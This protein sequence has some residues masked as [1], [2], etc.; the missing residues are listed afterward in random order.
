[1]I[2][3]RRKHGHNIHNV[4]RLDYF[5]PDPQA[6]SRAGNTQITSHLSCTLRCCR[7]GAAMM[8]LHECVPRITADNVNRPVHVC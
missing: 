7:S 3:T 1:M 2:W 5:P 8:M 6:M 4:K